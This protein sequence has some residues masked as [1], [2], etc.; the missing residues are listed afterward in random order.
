MNDSSETC[1]QYFT[2]TFQ[3]KCREA[4]IDSNTLTF[5]DFNWNDSN[6]IETYTIT[7]DIEDL[8]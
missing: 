5:R 4:T 6:V 1:A 8:Y 7:D 3:D 2:I